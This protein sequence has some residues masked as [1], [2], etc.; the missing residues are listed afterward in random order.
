MNGNGPSL[1]SGTRHL[2]THRRMRWGYERATGDA[3]RPLSLLWPL[4][5]LRRTTSRTSA[6]PR[7]AT[8]GRAAVGTEEATRG[9]MHNSEGGPMSRITKPLATCTNGCNAPPDPPSLV[10]C[11]AC[12]DKI[13][14]RLR[15]WAT[16]GY[17]DDD[18]ITPAAP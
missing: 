5:V 1:P 9:R 8:S 17:V 7:E 15:R 10:I 12:Q 14:G 16:Q 2:Q 4:C 3:V 18:P 13:T 11:R 6:L